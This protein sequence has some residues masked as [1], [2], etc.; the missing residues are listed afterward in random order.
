MIYFV[1]FIISM[2]AAGLESVTYFGFIVKHF[3]LSAYLIYFCGLLAALKSRQV[4]KFFHKIYPPA[5]Y[6]ITFAYFIFIFLE[7]THYPNYIY[8]KVHVNPLAFQLFVSLAWLHYLIQRGVS[9][10]KLLIIATLVYVGV[11]GA[12]RT[13]ANIHGQFRNIIHN[14]FMSYDRKMALAYPGFYPAMKEIVRL[15]PPSCYDSNPSPRQPL[16]NRGQRSYGYL[17]P[18]STQGSQSCRRSQR[19]PTN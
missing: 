19:D 2:L 9:F 10:S 1:L 6:L 11:D 15:T 18:L 16:G 17:L 8:T 5:V 3:H 4:P 12:G 13:I 7:T 14:P